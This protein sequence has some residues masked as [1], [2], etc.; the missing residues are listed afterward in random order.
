MLTMKTFTT[1]FGAQQN[2]SD[3]LTVFVASSFLLLPF[4]LIANQN[5]R[6]VC[7]KMSLLPTSL[8]QR[9]QTWITS[10]KKRLKMNGTQQRK[11]RESKQ[12]TM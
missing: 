12:P 2:I 11:K 1:T 4:K 5:K 10:W 6:I 7:D 8:E 3:F 9:G